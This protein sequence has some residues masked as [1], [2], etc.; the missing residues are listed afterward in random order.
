MTDPF[1]GL[2]EAFEQDPEF[3]ARLLYALGLEPP[4]DLQRCMMTL[5]Y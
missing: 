2:T 1:V 3:A 5:G 4:Q